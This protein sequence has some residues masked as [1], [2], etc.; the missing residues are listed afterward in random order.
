VIEDEPDSVRAGLVRAQKARARV[1]CSP[2]G[3]STRPKPAAP[4]S[5]NRALPLA[6]IQPQTSQTD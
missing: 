6:L 5:S 3:G 2:A 4:A 1:G